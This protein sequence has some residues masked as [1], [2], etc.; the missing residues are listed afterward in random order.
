MA[1]CGRFDVLLVPCRNINWFGYDSRC[2]LQNLEVRRYESATAEAGRMPWN[3]NW[4]L[5][6]LS[7]LISC[8]EMHYCDFCCAC[9]RWK[10]ASKLQKLL[11]RKLQWSHQVWIWCGFGFGFGLVSVSDNPIFCCFLGVV[12]WGWNIL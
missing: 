7:Q 6:D 3:E 2:I 1:F 10:S 12:G 5:E 4:A 8:K 9:F 11:Q